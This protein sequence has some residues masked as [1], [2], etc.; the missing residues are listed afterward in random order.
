MGTRILTIAF[1]ICLGACGSTPQLSDSECRA[2]EADQCPASSG[3]IVQ[4]NVVIDPERG[5]ALDELVDTCQASP[6]RLPLE[7]Q[8]CD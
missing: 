7:Y 8:P 5:C 3:C 1:V 2:F 6:L 4:T